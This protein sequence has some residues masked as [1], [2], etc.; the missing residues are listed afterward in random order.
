MAARTAIVRSWQSQ[1][2]G[3]DAHRERQVCG[4]HAR[5]DHRHV[6]SNMIMSLPVVRIAEPSG[7]LVCPSRSC[8]LV[9]S[10]PPSPTKL[11]DRPSKRS[12]RHDSCARS[13]ATVAGDDP[14]P[15]CT[16]QV[17]PC[18]ALGP[19]A[20]SMIVCQTRHRARGPLHFFSGKGP[21]R[22]PDCPQVRTT[23]S[24]RRLKVLG[25]RLKIRPDSAILRSYRP[26]V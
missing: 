21:H 8:S 1:K 26:L 16:T 7:R 15:A 20:A 18:G 24:R 22:F 4:S 10:S 5:P 25:S 11:V 3:L 23:L 6:T 13:R 2:L 17:P 14:A 9:G 19:K 12:S